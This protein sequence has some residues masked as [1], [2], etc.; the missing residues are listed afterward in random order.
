MGLDSPAMGY[1]FAAATQKGPSAVR[2]D[3]MAQGFS[4]LHGEGNTFALCLGKTGEDDVW[5]INADTEAA[6]SYYRMCQANAHNP[7][8]PRV[9]EIIEADYFFVVRIE[10]LTAPDHLEVAPSL[11]GYLLER[12]ADATAFLRGEDGGQS[13]LWK[14]PLAVEAARLIHDCAQSIYTATN[15]RTLT[16]IDNKPA[17]VFERRGVDGYRHLVFGDPLYPSNTS[18]RDFRDNLDF[19]N[20]ARAAFNL[21]SLLLRKGA[22]PSAMLP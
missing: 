13:A 7:Y 2:R 8:L 18:S 11:Q 12:G 14:D 15:G 10:R 4:P 22:E 3:L 20:R 9:K 5:M 6:L 1:S 16:Y 17:N 19:M 21:P